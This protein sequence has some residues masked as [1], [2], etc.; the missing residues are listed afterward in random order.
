MKRIYLLVILIL[1][2]LLHAQQRITIDQ[3]IDMALKHNF[4]IQVARNEANIDKINNTK[5]N[6]GMLPTVSLNGNGSYALNH[7]NQKLSNGTVNKYSAQ[8][9]IDLGANALLSWTLYDGGR[10][11]VT[12]NKL[13]EIQALGELQ[14]NAQ[15]LGVIYDVVSAYFDIV[16]QKQQLQSIN[17]VIRYN[18]QRVLIAQTGFNA[19]TL[20]K[21][22]LLQAQVDLNVA[23]E[24]AIN[25]QYVISRAEKALSTLL[26]QESTV[27]YSVSDSI[28]FRAIPNRAEMESRIESSNTDLQALKKQIDVANLSVKEAQKGLSPILKLQSELSLSHNYY[29]EGNTKRNNTAGM[30]VGGALSIPL[31]DAGETKRKTSVAK[32]QLLIAQINLANTRQQINTA[33][34]NE[35]NDYESQQQ[36][37]SIEKQNNLL[38]KENLEICLQRLKLGQTN[39]LEVHQAQESYAQSSTRL[40]NF[41]YNLKM[42]ETKLRQ[43]ISDL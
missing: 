28:P 14:F 9:N 29:S 16:C 31:Y 12:K 3:A 19:G 21:T 8:S 35:Y 18:Q 30:F 40:I 32:T 37:L 4:D 27:T 13:N 33:L 26:A 15:V 34:Q 23:K 39:S 11:F 10:M 38:A 5:G 24:N 20:A 42:Q 41:E 17:E 43:L 22:E 6:A 25:Q 7:I 2:L 1:P 36:L